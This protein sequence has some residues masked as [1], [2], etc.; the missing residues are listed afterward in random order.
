MAEEY[1]GSYRLLAS[2]SQ[3]QTA[4]EVKRTRARKRSVA[5]PLAADLHELSTP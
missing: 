1:V 2:M 5:V 3:S 4:R